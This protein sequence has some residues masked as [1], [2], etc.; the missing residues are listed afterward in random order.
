[1]PCIKNLCPIR[2]TTISGAI[3]I[4]PQVFLIADVYI[5]EAAIAAWLKVKVLGILTIF[6]SKYGPVSVVN[7][8]T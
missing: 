6:G 7:R 2:Y 3:I 5:V 1:M 4:S 8:L